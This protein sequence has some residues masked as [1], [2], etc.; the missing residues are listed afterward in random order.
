[1]P[2]IPSS[3]QTRIRILENLEIMLMEIYLLESEGVRGLWARD[4]TPGRGE[5][6]PA[7]SSEGEKRPTNFSEEEI[8]TLM[9][10][11]RT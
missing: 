1:M 7:E 5:K 11:L 4:V 6:A 9:A 2:Q 10:P 8:S 3:L